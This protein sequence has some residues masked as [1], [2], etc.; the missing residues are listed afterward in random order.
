[1]PYAIITGGSSGIGL[2]YSEVFAERGYDL[3]IVSNREDLNQSAQDTL[4]RQYPDVAV[5][6]LYMDL[7]DLG[8][9]QQLLDYCHEKGLDWSTMP[10]CFISGPWW[11]VPR[12]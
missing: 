1:M 10:A 6:T 11:T 4:R 7:T 5:D 3:L 9:P 2:A 8:A 12:A